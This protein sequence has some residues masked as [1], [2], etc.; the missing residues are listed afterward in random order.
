MAVKQILWA[1]FNAWGNAYHT[2]EVNLPPDWYG[3]QASLHGTQGGGTSYTGVVS[4]RKRLA[5]GVDEVHGFGEWYSWP[6]VV[7]DYLSS[8]TF[9]IG[10]VSGQKAWML[11]RLDRW[12]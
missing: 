8:V 5:S 12:G 11:A 3:A 1:G 9:G 6:P 2:I 4:Y 10:T 7:F